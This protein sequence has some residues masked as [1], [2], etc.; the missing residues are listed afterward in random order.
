MGKSVLSNE[1]KRAIAESLK[2][3]ENKEQ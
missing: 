1:E 3:E 2:K